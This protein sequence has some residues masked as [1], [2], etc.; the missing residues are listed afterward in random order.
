MLLNFQDQKRFQ[1]QLNTEQ[2]AFFGSRPS[3]AR[4]LGPKKAVGPRANGGASN[5][6]PTRRLS[7]NTHH[8]SSNGVRSVSRD[9][10][11]E[12][13]RAAAP[14][15]YVALAKEDAVSH[16]SGSDPAPASP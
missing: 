4:P 10:R 16:V 5:G 11:R 6:T 7:L 12:A 9:G 15:N 14:V 13:S 8:G 1:E 3:P 2:E